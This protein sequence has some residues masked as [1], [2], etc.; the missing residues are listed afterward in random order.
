M[1][2]NT[3]IRFYLQHLTFSPAGEHGCS[4]TKVLAAHLD[5]FPVQ[6]FRFAQHAPEAFVG[7]L[8]TRCIV[9]D[10]ELRLINLGRANAVDIVLNVLKC[11]F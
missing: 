4:Y 11:R 2:F 5:R 8:F 7:N 10:Y 6:R 9:L 1:G 3:Y